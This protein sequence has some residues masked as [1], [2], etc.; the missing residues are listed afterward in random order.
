MNKSFKILEPSIL[1]LFNVVWNPYILNYIG[2]SKPYQLDILF[3]F[4]NIFPI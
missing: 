3:I 4:M 1:Q 2:Q